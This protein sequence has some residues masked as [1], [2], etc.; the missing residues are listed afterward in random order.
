MLCWGSDIVVAVVVV[1][2]FRSWMS[3]GTAGISEGGESRR[4]HGCDQGRGERVCAKSRIGVKRWDMQNDL[5]C[6]ARRV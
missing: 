3:F 5:H 2:S 1:V 6:L 4:C